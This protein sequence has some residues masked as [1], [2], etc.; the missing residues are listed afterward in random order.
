[1]ISL[2]TK[3]NSK[4][5]KDTKLKPEKPKLLPENTSNIDVGN[6]A[7]NRNSKAQ[8]I[9]SRWINRKRCNYKTS[10]QHPEQTANK[11]EELHRWFILQSGGNMEHIQRIAQIK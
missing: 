9:A 3:V 8:K 1:M 6:N 5:V 4:L 10:A 7:L 2:F 11:M